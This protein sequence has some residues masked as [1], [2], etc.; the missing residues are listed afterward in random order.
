MRVTTARRTLNLL[1]RI[2]TCSASSDC[3]VI[4][5]RGKPSAAHTDAV[6]TIP[7]APPPDPSLLSN[8]TPHSH[9]PVHQMSWV[10]CSSTLRHMSSLLVP[11]RAL[12]ENTP[13]ARS[14]Q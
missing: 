11:M 13:T 1:C 2:H 14:A 9:V 3:S 5:L 7:T 12:R 8:H 4:Q 10:A 6:F